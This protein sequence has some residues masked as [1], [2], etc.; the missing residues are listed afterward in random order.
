MFQVP[1]Q[2]RITDEFSRIDGGA[3]KE[4]SWRRQ[5][6]G[7]G[8]SR[9]LEDGPIL[10]KAGINFSHVRGAQLPPSATANRPELTGR[11]FEALGVSVVVHPRNPYA[12]TSHMNV[13]A[14][15][16]E[17]EHEPPVWWFGGGFDLTPFYGFDEDCRHWHGMAASCCAPFGSEVYPRFKTWCDDYFRLPHRNESRGI[18]GLFFDDLNE[19]GFERCL[20]FVRAM[21][22][23]YLD[24]YLPILERRCRLPFGD[25]ERTFQLYRRGR[26]V[27][28]NLL[29]DRG[30]IFGLQ[31]GGR[32]E[33]ILMSLPPLV[34]WQYGKTFPPGSPEETLTSHYLKP[35]DWLA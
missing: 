10:E 16:A 35:Q 23:C 22:S 29:Y 27:E 18:G 20:S 24:A 4:D 33:S 31:S 21:G 15:L 7:G 32:V 28:F 17:R 25:R 19:W 26:Y 8:R 12:P 34:T 9:V 14:F 30:T 2:D 13:R 5:G 3:F 1:L 6:G 11:S